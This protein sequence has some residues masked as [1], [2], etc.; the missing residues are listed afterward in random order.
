MAVDTVINPLA[1]DAAFR[2]AEAAR[3]LTPAL[4][5]DCDRVKHNIATTLNLL[6]GDANRWRPHVKTAKLAY[7]M[8]MFV[9]AG[10]RQFKCATS[11]ELS[12]ACEAGAQDVLVAY[13]LTGANAARVRQIAE[14]HR[15]VAVSVLVE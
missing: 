10:I 7:V 9:D 2:V 12:V 6:G 14:E 5:I 4:L 11:L 13:P 3:M 15:G 1:S 8:R